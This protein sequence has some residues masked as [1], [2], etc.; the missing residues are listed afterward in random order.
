MFVS[1]G[2]DWS[3]LAAGLAASARVAGRLSCSLG[4]QILFLCSLSLILMDI[5]VFLGALVF[6]SFL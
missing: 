2:T 6:Y 1:A 4:N 5:L 3:N